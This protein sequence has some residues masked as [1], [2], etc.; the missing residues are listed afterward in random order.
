MCMVVCR[1]IAACSAGLA[2]SRRWRDV[3]A[4]V[5]VLLVFAAALGGSYLG[6]AV[7]EI[8]VSASWL[9]A[10]VST[11]RSWADVTSWTPWG[12]PWALAGDAAEG[13]WA[14]FGAHLLVSLVYLAAGMAAYAKLLDK[15]MITPIKPS[16]AKARTTNVVARLTNRSW[17]RPGILPA[18]AVMAR[19]L[20]YWRSDPR[21]IITFPTMIYLA[22]LFAVL[23]RFT[24]MTEQINVS[25]AAAGGILITALM[26]GMSLSADLAYDSTAWWLHLSSALRGW[27]DRAGRVAA[28]A[29]WGVPLF[30]VLTV[31]FA[32]LTRDLAD[33]VPLIG[34]GIGTLLIGMGVSS[35]TSAL[36]IYPVALPGESPMK[37]KTGSM[38]MQMIGQFSTMAVTALL[39]IPIAVLGAFFHD[40]AGWL[41]LLVGIVWGLGMAVVGIVGGGAIVDR[42]GAAI[43]TILKRNDTSS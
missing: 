18:T 24:P 41:V 12:A 9:E 37:S 22:G 32:W 43:L 15:A 25:A 10:L 8:S 36:F 23:I 20:R 27:A 1:V 31:L 39:A 14:T 7:E 2:D 30:A 28:M 35:V 26:S 29:A 33:A 17:V 38:A 42:R 6:N 13:A 19:C 16:T 40:S 5:G 3:T 21:Y 11:M 4:V 34:V